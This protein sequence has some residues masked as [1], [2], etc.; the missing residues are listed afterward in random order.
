MAV[1]TATA[2][3]LI[4]ACLKRLGVIDCFEFILSCESLGT[5]KREP[6]I[7]LESARRF[8]AAPS[9]VAVYEDAF[10]AAETAKKAGFYLVAVYD[11]EEDENWE[12][13]C[14]LADEGVNLN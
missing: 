14:S 2:E 3:P 12:K 11:D 5:S 10:Y 7:Y 13:I 9:E 1:A 4:E 8:D 6:M